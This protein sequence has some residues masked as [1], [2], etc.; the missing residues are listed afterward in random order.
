MERRGPIHSGPFDLA[1]TSCFKSKCKCVAWTDGDGCQRCYRLKKQCL[2]S[3]SIR[4]RSTKEKAAS[5]ARIAELENKLD[6]LISKLESGNIIVPG[7]AQH[8]SPRLEPRSPRTIS[9]RTLATAANEAQNSDHIGGDGHENVESVHSSGSPRHLTALEPLDQHVSEAEAETFLGTFRSCMLH[10]F[11]FLHLSDNLTAHELRHEWPFLFRAIICAT[12]HSVREKAARG[13]KFKRAIR[14]AMLGEESLPSVN[15]LDLLLAPMTYIS[16]GWDHV[17]NRGSLPWLMLQATSLA[18]EIQG[19]PESQDARMTALF[20]PG[21][22]S[23]SENTGS[24]TRQAFLKRHRAIL[25]CFVLS[26]IISTYYGQGDALRWTPLMDI[27][28][29][30]I[31]TSKSC[32]TD[33]AFAIQVNL[34]LLAQESLRIHQQQRLEKGEV[35]AT[36]M[37]SLPTLTGLTTLQEHLKALQTSISPNVS[38]RELIMA[39]IYATKLQI[40]ESICA[41][42]SMVPIMIS[43]FARMVGTRPLSA[44]GDTTSRATPRRERLQCLWQC[45]RHIQACTSVLLALPLFEFGCIS[46]LQWAQLARCVASLNRLTTIEEITWD[47]ALGRTIE[48]PELL[49]REAYKL[50]QVAQANGEQDPDELFA[51]LARSMREFCSNAVDS[52]VRG[53]GAA[54]QEAEEDAFNGNTATSSPEGI[55]PW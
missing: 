48:V 50:E 10:H 9:V 7:T 3:D 15:K 27:G 18:Y 22:V 35:A 38:H 52:A 31:S 1:C 21:W 54:D 33:A 11:A 46:F 12:S 49:G 17:L 36:H 55:I 20:T 39:H 41:V 28:L 8:S 44:P 19:E 40:S 43:Q 16:W 6:C 26:S 13:R 53:N 25:G 2:Q 42:N 29:V 37:S 23:M 24:M 47:D 45:V 51:K 14:E 4:R 34:Q 5:I 30:V 32:S